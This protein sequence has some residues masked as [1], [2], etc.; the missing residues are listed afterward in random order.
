MNVIKPL[1]PKLATVGVILAAL[2]VLACGPNATPTPAPTPAPAPT[3]TPDP[4]PTQTPRPEPTPTQTPKPELTPT[5]TPKPE[6][7]PEIAPSRE[8]FMPQDANLV[9]DVNPAALL[10]SQAMMTILDTLTT[11]TESGDGLFEEFE[12]EVGVS[13]RSIQL[14]ELFVDLEM[15]LAAGLSAESAEDIE[16]PMMGVAL[17]GDLDRSDFIARLMKA[18]EEDPEVEYAVETYRDHDLYVDPNSGLDG[19]S[20]SF[21]DSGTL[22][23]GTTDGVKAMI[24]VSEGAAPALSGEAMQAL[25]ALGDRHLGIIMS[26]PPE[27]LEVAAQGSEDSMAMLG[28]LDPTALSSPLTVMNMLAGDGGFEIQAKQFFEEETDAMASKEY[29]EGTMAMLGAMAGS[30]GIQELVTAMT[31]SQSGREVYYDLTISNA[32]IEEIAN[33]LSPFGEMSSAEPQRR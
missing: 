17:R 27:L 18:A 25:D 13:L 14:V 31:I 11:A 5:Q 15:A 8:T 3:A 32:Q 1:I 22:L 6:P 19:L 30:P 2:L 21:V 7:T 16:V 29:S 33:F 23:L 12:A 9:I 24:D 26:T 20:F 28:L 10:D 4:T